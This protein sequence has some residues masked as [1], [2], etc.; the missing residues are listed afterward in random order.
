MNTTND[1]VAIAKEELSKRYNR[2]V[3]TSATNL[4]TH[5]GW[6]IDACHVY[7]ATN[8]PSK[9]PVGLNGKTFEQFHVFYR[10]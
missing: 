8:D 1:N 6:C 3:G 9:S 5:C 4:C 7:L 10:C 2:L